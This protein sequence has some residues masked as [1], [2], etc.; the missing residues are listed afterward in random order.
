MWM[1]HASGYTRLDP[2][3]SDSFFMLGCVLRGFGVVPYAFLLADA[4]CAYGG[5][6]VRWGLL[7]VMILGSLLR[8][9]LQ[10]VSLDPGEV[11]EDGVV[12]R[13]ISGLDALVFPVLVC[14]AMAL[15]WMYVGVT[16]LTIFLSLG[17][18]RLVMG[19]EM[20]MLA[21]VLGGVLSLVMAILF[22][23]VLGLD[24]VGRS[25]SRWLQ[26]GFVAI[27]A[28]LL[29]VL[30]ATR[31]IR[32]R[33]ETNYDSV[34]VECAVEILSVLVL[35]LN[36]NDTGLRFATLEMHRSGTADICR[37]LAYLGLLAVVLSTVVSNPPRDKKMRATL[38]EVDV[39]CQGWSSLIF[40]PLL[41][42]S[43]FVVL[44]LVVLLIRALRIFT[45]YKWF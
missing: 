40:L 31:P 23:S 24:P 41:Q 12:T 16:V 1:G 2:S 32:W 10:W 39:L 8:M 34:T 19:S 20:G 9:V 17:V 4:A 7:V 22:S 18:S 28:I 6:L 43:P 27:P 45:V 44:P 30:S 5:G 25:E 3:K 26:T 14:N 36:T 13:V 37:V 42:L 29:P 33:I 38:L 15:P 35:F 21:V 11:R